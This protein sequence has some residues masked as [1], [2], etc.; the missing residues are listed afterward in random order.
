MAEFGL[1]FGE[2][3]IKVVEV[4]KKDFLIEVKKIAFSENPFNIYVTDSEQDLKK[5]ADSIKK[6]I[7]DAGIKKKDVNIVIPDT[8][9]YSQIIEMPLMTEKE[10]S[11]AIKYHADQF[12]PIPIDKVG[13][14]IEVLLV[15]EQAKKNTIMLVASPNTIINKVTD[16]AEIAGLT[17]NSIENE[18]SSIIRFFFETLKF[19]QAQVSTKTG[20]KQNGEIVMIINFGISTSSIYLLDMSKKMPLNIHNFT[21]GLDILIKD[22][23]ANYNISSADVRKIFAA[24]GFSKNNPS[25]DLDKILSAPV[26][27][28]VSE[29]ERFVTASK[30]KFNINI[31]KTFLIGEGFGILSFDQKLSTSLSMPIQLFN[32]FSYLIKNPLTESFRNNLALFIAAAGACLRG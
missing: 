15:D 29:I 4:E 23:K 31:D 16:L 22:I 9:S 27:E 8:H 3:Y 32:P 12:I 13:M 7:K 17:P 6:L 19:N 25:L 20:E 21:L 2:N 11:T 14:D 10:L 1:D 26:S 24:V 28:F 30:S 18:A 5:V